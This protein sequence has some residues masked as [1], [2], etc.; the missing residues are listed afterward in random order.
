MKL[1]E[2]TLMV[3]EDEA[4]DLITILEYADENVSDL[5]YVK[6][7]IKKGYL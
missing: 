1:V 7:A 2:A 4:Q 5:V 3:T 6:N